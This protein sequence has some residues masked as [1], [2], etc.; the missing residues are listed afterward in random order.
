MSKKQKTTQQTTEKTDPWAPAIPFLTDA[1]GTAQGIFN[2]NRAL[3]DE[4]KAAVAQGS[5][6]ARDRLSNPVYGQIE[7]AASG[8]IGGDYAPNVRPVNVPG[9]ARSGMAG[10]MRSAAAIPT[11]A[12]GFA[13]KGLAAAGNAMGDATRGLFGMGGG[14][15]Q[16]P[17]AQGQVAPSTPDPN[18][19]IE[20]VLSG[21]VD[22][23][24]LAAMAD[25]A[26]RQGQRTYGDAVQD[27]ADSFTRTIAP[28]IRSGAS[29][30]GGYGGSRQGI[31][32]G[33][34]LA[35]R[36]KTLGRAARDL[37]I[38]ANDATAN[39]Y[40]QAYESAQ[41]RMASMADSQAGRIQQDRQYNQGLAL[42][43]DRFGLDQQRFGLDRD[44]FTTDVGFRNNEQEMQRAQQEAAQ[45]TQGAGL[46]G[47]GTGLQSQDLD[48]WLGMLGYE[49]DWEQSQFAPLLQA[50][51]G[52]GGMGRQSSGTSTGTTKVND[53]F[54]LATNL[55]MAA[56]MASGSD[57]SIKRNVVTVGHDD[58][59]RRWVTFNYVWEPEGTPSHRGV[60]AQELQKIDPELV[61]RHP[62]GFLTVDYAGLAVKLKEAA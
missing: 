19:A 22:N 26:T 15:G 25:A 41:G 60:I 2:R 53:P 50:V 8:L 62:M 40:G 44:R 5:Q 42:D 61:H 20:K 18:A 59:G 14:V 3:S 45:A 37:G 36:E 23:P 54:G 10:I 32:E 31:A 12:M 29:L 7:Q 16:G 46:F 56:A 51:T 27:S 4:Q 13:S 17:Q 1:M 9:Q 57:A 47:M 58:A 24:Q 21:Q 39:L 28:S 30:S 43:R 55:A 38:A 49:A 48:R 52:I 11:N 35:E 33:L 6:M 34:A